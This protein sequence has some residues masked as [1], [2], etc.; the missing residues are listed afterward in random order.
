MNKLKVT[1]AGLLVAC[2]G[3]GVVN[4]QDKAAATGTKPATAKKTTKKTSAKK[5]ATTA[6]AAASSTQTKPATKHMKKDGTP[7][8]RY[9]ENKTT[10]PGDAAK[11]ATKSTTKKAGT[12]KASPKKAAA[13]NKGM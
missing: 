7:D 8:K 13:A 9:K 5:E 2:L 4:A 1:I 11:P 3:L 10:T 6:P 12:K